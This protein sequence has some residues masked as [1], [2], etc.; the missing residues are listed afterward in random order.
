M[1]KRNNTSVV[2]KSE[3]IAIDKWEGDEIRSS[4]KL[5]IR[6]LINKQVN[7]WVALDIR[8]LQFAD[9]NFRGN[10]RSGRNNCSAQRREKSARK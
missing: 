8:R 10:L 3:R 5:I 1:E 6:G 4:V 9:K 7:I 2:R